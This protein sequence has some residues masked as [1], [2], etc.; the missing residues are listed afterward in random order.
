MAALSGTP[1]V[2]PKSPMQPVMRPTTL[3]FTS[4]FV[5]KLLTAHGGTAVHQRNGVKIA[6]AVHNEAVQVGV[7]GRIRLRKSD[8]SPAPRRPWLH[9]LAPQ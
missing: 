1:A 2:V 8:Q 5:E 4:A 7:Y 9:W 6:S 3:V